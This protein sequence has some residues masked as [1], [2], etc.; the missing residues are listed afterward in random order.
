MQV[1]PGHRECIHNK[2]YHEVGISVLQGSKTSGDETAGPWLVTEDFAS[3]SESH[4]FICGVAYR[5]SNNNNFYDVGEGLG[6]VTV[7][8]AGV[9]AT[10]ISSASGAYAVPVSANGSYTVSFKRSDLPSYSTSAT[11]ADANNV[12]VD[13]A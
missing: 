13:Y 4:A 8:V 3:S 2:E 11:I 6:S 1:P 7:T 9:T 5:D 12:K 10:G